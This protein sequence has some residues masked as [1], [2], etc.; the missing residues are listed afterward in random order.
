M[1]TI[2]KLFLI[3]TIAL[4]LG[5]VACSDSD[6][7]SP[8]DNDSKGNTH[9][10]V[11]LKL[12]KGLSTRAVENNDED[13][14]YIGKWAGADVIKT[15]SIYV[16]DGALVVRKEFNVGDDYTQEVA[17]DDNTVVLTPKKSAAIKT[18]AGGK[19]VYVV[20]NE[21]ETIKTVLASTSPSTFAKA[22]EE[23]ALTLASKNLS[24]TTSASQL[25]EVEA[26]KDY[27][28]MTNVKPATI[29]VK[30]NVSKA[31][32]IEAINGNQASL[33]VERTVA[34]VLVTLAKY[35]KSEIKDAGEVKIGTVSNVHWV[36]A[37]GEQSLFVQRKTNWATPNFAWIPNDI[38][39]DIENVFI[40]K[41]G[42]RY[43]Y[44]GLFEGLANTPGFGGTTLTPGAKSEGAGAI[45]P[46]SVRA[47]KFILATT[48]KHAA[49]PADDNAAYAGGY[50]KGNTAYVM[51][52][53]KFTPTNLADGGDLAADG[54]FWYG[55]NGKFYS[56]AKNVL[57]PAQNGVV[58]QTAAKYVGGKVLYY[59]WVNPDQ[60]ATPYNSPVLRNNIYHI[61]ITGFKTIGTNWNPLFP[62]NPERELEDPSKPYHPTDNPYKDKENPDPKPTPDPDGPEEPTNPIDP[63]DPLTTPET[64]MSVKVSVLPWKVHSYEI[65][66]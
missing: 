36:L 10:S 60:V 50:K 7:V 25:A 2:H 66:L 3:A 12:A 33:E 26:E 41:A 35:F 14:N 22:Y 57:D 65:E 9:M 30:P 5:F 29:D 11:T 52:R 15:V 37:Q 62:E 24:A 46:A 49:A 48:H 51:V 42:A 58:G 61:H 43:D 40:A 20:I 39:T 44:S 56:S 23:T 54:T 16:I 32:S 38:V 1:K 17:G 4:G 31:A 34:R 8:G 59:A 55:A 13:Y 6:V 21:N 63:E 45:G 28:V 27:I 19:T 18:T 64:W 53:A 47:G